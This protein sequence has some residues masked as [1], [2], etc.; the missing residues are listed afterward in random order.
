[1]TTQVTIPIDL[2]QYPKDPGR[3]PTPLAS[4]GDYE[5]AYA[6]T[7]AE[8]DEIFQ[9]RYEVFNLEMQEGLDTAHQ[10]QRD[11]DH[12]D[13]TCH[14]VIVR[15][16]PTG[17]IVGTYR[18]Q[19]KSMAGALGFYGAT[20]F[21]LSALPSS[22]LNQAIEVGR[23]CIARDHRNGRVLVRLWR[24]VTRYLAHNRMRYLFGCCSINSQ[25]PVEGE[26]IRQWLDHHGYI[27]SEFKV[28]PQ[29]GYECKPSKTAVIPTQVSIPTLM[30]LY[31]QND[32]LVL[33]TPAIDRTFKTIDYFVLLDADT[34]SEIT[35]KVLFADTP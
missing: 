35:R 15:H 5:V 16:C 19:T 25:D 4:R 18:L 32:L 12:Y 31:L 29:P 3:I 10:Y 27:N 6:H 30:R 26:A 28:T 13:A 20:E 23:A 8:L 1:M 21:D 14:H 17:Q 33:G 34:I 9:L 24:G 7:A 2:S 22:V 11:F